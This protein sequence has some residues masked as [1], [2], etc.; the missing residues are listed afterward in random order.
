MNK[1]F[2]FALTAFYF[3]CFLSEAQVP[4]IP[5]KEEISQWKKDAGDAFKNKIYGQ[6]LNLYKKLVDVEPSNAEYNYRLGVSYL[7]TNIDKRKAIEYLEMAAQQKDAPKDIDYDLGIAYHYAGEFE[8]STG[9]FE[10][11]KKSKGGNPNPK[12]EVNLRM[13]WN[14][15]APEIMRAPVEVEFKNLGKSVNT[16]YAEIRPVTGADDSVLVFT[17]MRKGTMGGLT[18]E[19]GDFPS[20]IFTSVINDSLGN[21]GKAKNPGININ[22]EVYDESLSLNAAG[23]KMLIYREGFGINGDIFLAELKGKAW[24]KAASLGE[25]FVTK[26]LETGACLSPDG[27]TLYFTSDMKGTKGGKD[28]WMCT[29]E[30]AAWSK[31]VNLGEPINT[32]YDE[33]NPMLFADGVTLFF[34]SRGHNSMGGYDLFMTKYESSQGWQ[35]PKNIGYPLNTLYDDQYFTL[36]ADGKTGYISA[37]RDSGFGDMDI[38]KVTLAQPLVNT[39][40][41][42]VKFT[43]MTPSGGPGKNLD[44]VITNKSTGAL[45]GEYTTNSSTGKFIAALPAGEYKINVKPTKLGRVM[46]EFTI[47]ESEGEKVE[48][49]FTLAFE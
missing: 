40:L 9:A 14:I 39:S 27:K 35:K 37:L 45:V 3:V 34:S 10:K 7:N 32:K 42:I 5:T 41:R 25:A 8:K 46:Q 15:N 6:S 28:L 16:A 22:S 43:I 23:D 30:G 19:M 49:V 1:K 20:D 21:R 48:K 13:E 18:D 11:F 12:L 26:E 44:A 17:T 29:K 33:D 47:E 24:Q 38:Y 4:K 31:P 2:V 36:A